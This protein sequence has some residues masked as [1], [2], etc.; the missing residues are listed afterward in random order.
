MI[1]REQFNALITGLCR[2]DQGAYQRIEQ[3]L[4][5]RPPADPY[6]AIPKTPVPKPKPLPAMA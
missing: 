3:V 4:L 1:P 6:G 5:K 2:R